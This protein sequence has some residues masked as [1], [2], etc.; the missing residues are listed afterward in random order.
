MLPGVPG[1]VRKGRSPEAVRRERNRTRL[2]PER[3]HRSCDGNEHETELRQDRHLPRGQPFTAGSLDKLSRLSGASRP[4][5]VTAG[6]A[7]PA[8]RQAK[9]MVLEPRYSQPCTPETGGAKE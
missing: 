6:G 9:W 7:E 2:D 8:T 1:R 3:E 4:C 5:R